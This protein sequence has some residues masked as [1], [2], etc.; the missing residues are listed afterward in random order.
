MSDRSSVRE[1]DSVG[2]FALFLFFWCTVVPPYVMCTAVPGML[3]PTRYGQ[4]GVQAAVHVTF[5]HGVCVIQSGT[6]QVQSEL[7]CEA[8][9]HL[10][11]H[12]VKATEVP[13]TSC[14]TLAPQSCQLAR[15]LSQRA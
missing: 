5:M 10:L 2:V 8:V 11:Q 14:R 7:D 3:P 12:P 13:G 9:L 6:V 15:R 4:R 1:E